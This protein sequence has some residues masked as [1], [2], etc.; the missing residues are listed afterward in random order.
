MKSSKVS[1]IIRMRRA[2]IVKKLGALHCIRFR[3]SR[4]LG[5]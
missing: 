2:K 4:P 1:N 3:I 5:S